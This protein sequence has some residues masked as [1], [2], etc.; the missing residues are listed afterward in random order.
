MPV[1]QVARMPSLHSCRRSPRRKG[2]SMI[3][4]RRL[5]AV[6][7]ISVATVAGTAACASQQATDPDATVLKS[8]ALDYH[9]AGNWNPVTSD[10]LNLYFAP[11]QAVY[12]PL[13]RL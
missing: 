3:R 7:A 12:E 2:N 4:S 8:S 13:I 9:I 11:Q 5:A 1:R 10:Y 6:V